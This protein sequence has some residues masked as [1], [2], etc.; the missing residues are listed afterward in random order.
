MGGVLIFVAGEVARVRCC[1]CDGSSAGAAVVSVAGV[2]GDDFCTLAVVGVAGVAGDTVSTCVFV[3][4]RAVI[5]GA[6]VAGDNVSTRVYIHIYGVKS[7]ATAKVSSAARFGSSVVMVSLWCSTV[8]SL[9][10][11]AAT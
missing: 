11:S 1:G 7:R 8:P 9:C 2:A 4:T 3:P 6:G 5:V 10:R